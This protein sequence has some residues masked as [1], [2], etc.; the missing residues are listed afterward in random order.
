M[1]AL[2]KADPP[3]DIEDGLN[4]MKPLKAAGLSVTSKDDGKLVRGSLRITF[5]E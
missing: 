4:Q 5:D 3:R 2:L 1:S